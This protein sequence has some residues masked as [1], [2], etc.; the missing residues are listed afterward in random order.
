MNYTNLLQKIEHFEAA[1]KEGIRV[2]INPYKMLST[3][4]CSVLTR[5]L[6][7]IKLVLNDNGKVS[8]GL[9]IRQAEDQLK[10]AA[11]IAYTSPRSSLL[12]IPAAK[13]PRYASLTP[14]L[15]LAHKEKDGVLYEDWDKEDEY[16]HFALGPYLGQLLQDSILE[17]DITTQDIAKLRVEYLGEGKP[18]TGYTG[19]KIDIPIDEGIK[20]SLMGSKAYSK[21]LLQV[22][23]AHA[24][25]RVPN[26]MI[27]D[28]WHWDNVPE[29]FDSVEVPSP[30]SEVKDL[31]W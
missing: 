23:I 11:K 31:P 28:P 19:R 8:A 22:W 20:V 29:A 12:T 2:A 10:H 5:D 13:N 16:I 26:V 7:E 1:K 9:T 27:L 17:F 18:V 6:R 24:S 25:L 30:V 3:D 21:I 14:L 4:F 15:M